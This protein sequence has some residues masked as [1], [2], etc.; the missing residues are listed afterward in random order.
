V[1]FVENVNLD[2]EAGTLGRF[3][4]LFSGVE[5]FLLGTLV[6]VAPLYVGSAFGS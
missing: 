1:N 2:L 5:V 3:D 6:V 4:V